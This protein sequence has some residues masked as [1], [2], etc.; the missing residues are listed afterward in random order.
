MAEAEKELPKLQ[1]KRNKTPVT[2]QMEAVEC[3]AAALSMIL[4]YYKTYVPL[5]ELR[6]ECGVSRDGSKA[7]N[8]IKAAK[9]YG[10][11]ASGFNKEIADLKDIPTPYIVFWNFNHFLVVEGF[12][13]GKVFLNDPASGQRTVT[14][15]EFDL[16]FTGVILTFK[17][18]E[19]YVPQGAP[20]S[21]MASLKS[22]FKGAKVA[23]FYLVLSGIL[24]AIPGLLV[25]IFTKVFI[26]KYLI[27]KLTAWVYPLLIGMFITAILRGAL[28]WLQEYYLIKLETKLSVSLSAKFLWH[29]LRLPLNFFSQRSPGDVSSRIALNDRVAQALSRRFMTTIISFILAIFYLALM[30]YY[31]VV[32]TLIAVASAVAIAGV[33]EYLN[34]KRKDLSQSILMDGAKLAGKSMDGLMAIETLKASG[35]E[36]DFFAQWSGHQAKMVNGMQKNAVFSY[37]TATIP[38]LLN[39]LNTALILGI[40]SLHVMSGTMTI[41]ML[42]AFQS[43]TSSFLSPVSTLVSASAEFSDL[44]GSMLRLDDVLNHDIADT[45]KLI[46]N[47][48]VREGAT[49]KPKLEGYLE[50]KD[51]SFGYSPLDPPLVENFN[52]KVKPGQRVALVGTTGCGKSTVSKLVMGLYTAWSGE[53]LFDGVPIHDVPRPTLTNSLAAVD[54]SISLFE[55]SI[56][57]N[58]T[59]WDDSIPEHVY[60]QAAKDA[61]IHDD[62]MTRDTGY[63]SKVVE[64]GFNFSGGQRQ[65]LEI[66]RALAIMP[67]IVVMDEA[68]SAL[69]PITEVKVDKSIRMRGCTCLIVAHRLSTIRDCD[70]II[71][72]DKGKIV[73]RG[74]HDELYDQEGHYQELIKAI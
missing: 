24:L 59:L 6:V 63:D 2:L 74:T 27:E 34:R 17:P 41:G 13:G 25:P 60:I 56:S 42:V 44:F 37:S 53:I 67:R 46:E 1:V 55:G 68:T 32:L 11:E 12:K 9:K 19:S 65:R 50:L 16:S 69:D 33:S 22:R 23:L 30:F 4:G 21:I 66:A 29:V 54:Q 40:G 48:E 61:C 15:E 51:V 36:D 39:G 47:K 20:P 70:E 14:M 26:D 10:L 45:V 28:T 62:I 43:L 72:L 57:E 73:Q 8:V 49:E 5:E 7:I 18:S 52:L 64:G 3:G 38:S 71:V 58:I 31:N 35:R